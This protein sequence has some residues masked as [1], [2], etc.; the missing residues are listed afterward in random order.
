MDIDASK[1]ELAK[2]VLEIEDSSVIDK[3]MDI[4][5]TENTLSEKQREAIDVAIA[6][7]ERGETISHELVMENTRKRYPKYFQ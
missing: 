6:Q 3:I 7:S 2:M 4:L 1:I 5:R